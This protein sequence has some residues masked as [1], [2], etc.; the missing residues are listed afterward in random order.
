MSKP[1]KANGAKDAD[2]IQVLRSDASMGEQLECAND[3]VDAAQKRCGSGEYDC[4][5]CLGL[6]YPVIEAAK[7]FSD[8]PASPEIVTQLRE[9][10]KRAA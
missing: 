4:D 10:L 3:A 1:H 7:V 6:D 2:T 5:S 8:V 9:L